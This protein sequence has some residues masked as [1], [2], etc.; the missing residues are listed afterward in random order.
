MKNVL[1]LSLIMA[2]LFC[3]C[4]GTSKTNEVKTVETTTASSDTALTYACSMHPEIMGKKGD[5]C[6]EC[7]MELTEVA[8]TTG[9]STKMK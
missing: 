6:S 8:Q 5:K 1:L 9:D 3:S 7:S 4:G 2:F